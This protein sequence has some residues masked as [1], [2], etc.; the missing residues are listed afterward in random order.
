MKFEIIESDN[1]T[2]IRKKKKHAILRLFQSSSK[3]LIACAII[4]IFQKII[5]TS[6]LLG[7]ILLLAPFYGLWDLL[8]K[9]NIAV[10]G[11]QYNVDIKQNKIFHNE[12]TSGFCSDVRIIEWNNS[13]IQSEGSLPPPIQIIYHDGNKLTITDTESN[14]NNENLRI[15]KA[16][17]KRLKVEFQNNHFLCKEILFYG[18]NEFPETLINQL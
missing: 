5:F 10:D 6:N 8:K 7:Y 18:Q 13:P 4:F 3:F 17:A 9:F 1:S 16:L 11:D 14:S 12:A 15:G 2:T